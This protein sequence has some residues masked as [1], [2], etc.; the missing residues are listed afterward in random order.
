MCA[1]CA[2]DAGVIACFCNLS[3]PWG[4]EADDLAPVMPALLFAPCSD[5]IQS[6]LSNSLLWDCLRH[7]HVHNA[8]F[9]L[10]PS[11]T[12]AD[13]G[14]A[15]YVRWYLPVHFGPCNTYAVPTGLAVG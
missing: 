5:D 15:T 9:L 7:M 8:A 3:A 12:T 10:K 13:K 4:T 11:R 6:L 1:G 14:T 2:V